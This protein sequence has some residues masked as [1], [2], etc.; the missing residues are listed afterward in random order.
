M[1]TLRFGHMRFFDPRYPVYFSLSHGQ[2]MRRDAEENQLLPGWNSTSSTALPVR[3]CCVVHVEALSTT[4]W[5][6]K[7]DAKY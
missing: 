7:A 6:S 2:S 1:G 3:G 5:S 4:V